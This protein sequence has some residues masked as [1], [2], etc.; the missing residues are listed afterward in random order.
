MN[1]DNFLD[2]KFVWK[3]K[4]NNKEDADDYKNRMS[5]STANLE[6]DNE[7]TIFL[8]MT[9]NMCLLTADFALCSRDLTYLP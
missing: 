5:K 9:Y 6:N 2:T 1:M 7:N 4:E 8:D 3:K